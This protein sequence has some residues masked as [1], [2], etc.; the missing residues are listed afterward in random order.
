MTRP[1]IFIEPEGIVVS[2]LPVPVPAWVEQ[3]FGFFKTFPTERSM[4]SVKQWT[5][6]WPNARELAAKVRTRLCDTEISL[7]AQGR[8]R[9]L[10]LW[11]TNRTI[12]QRHRAIVANLLGGLHRN[13]WFDA[14]A[15]AALSD[16][17][18]AGFLVCFVSN[19]GHLVKRGAPA[20]TILAYWQYVCL[21]LRGMQLNVGKQGRTLICTHTEDQKCDCRKPKPGMLLRAAEQHGIDLAESWLIEREEEPLRAAAQLGMKAGLLRASTSLWAGWEGIRDREHE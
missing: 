21:W 12:P 18:N 3:A 19:Q 2:P 7:V 17:E 11:W 13:G 4:N 1:A 6:F 14:D 8:T 20:A 9:S 10:P 15:L 5:A 16:M